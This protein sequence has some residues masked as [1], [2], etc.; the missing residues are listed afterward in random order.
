MVGS[1]QMQ[2]PQVQENF[3]F[4]LRGRG[5]VRVCAEQTGRANVALFFRPNPLF[6]TGHF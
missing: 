5:S 3:S 6:T 2:P 4:P 1:H